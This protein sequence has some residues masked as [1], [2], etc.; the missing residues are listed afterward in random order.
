M[1][2]PTDPTSAALFRAANTAALA[3]WLLLAATLVVPRLRTWGWRVTG[4]GLPALL[5]VTYAVTLAAAFRGG[6]TGG[7]DTIAHVRALF[8]DDR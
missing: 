5:A 3:A 1:P 4:L 8:A 7:F 6:A 2:T